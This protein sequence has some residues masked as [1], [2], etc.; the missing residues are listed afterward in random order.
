MDATLRETEREFRE[1]HHMHRRLV[2]KRVEQTGVFRSQHMT[3]MYISSHEGCSQKEIADAHQVSGA[4]VAVN[5]K[6]LEKMG[7]VERVCD[8]HD[9]RC[10]RITIT[11]AGADVVR[12]SRCIFEMIDNRMF[13][14]LTPDELAVF[15]RCLDK[16]RDQLIEMIDEAD[17][18]E[19]T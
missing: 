8:T 6:K 13:S 3:L 10:N 9:S 18:G 12:R 14:T 16:I 17:A 4:A 1:V 5:L 19:S 7:L 11:P 2:E 15:R